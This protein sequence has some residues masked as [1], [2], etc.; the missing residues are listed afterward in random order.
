MEVCTC[1]AVLGQAAASARGQPS[2]HEE[3][4]AAGGTYAELFTLQALP[5]Q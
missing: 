5:Y 3:L 1:L 4:V 2:T